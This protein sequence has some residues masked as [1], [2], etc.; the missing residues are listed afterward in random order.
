MKRPITKA[1]IRSEIERQIDSY[2]NGGGKVTNV[3]RG[4]SG[5]EDPNGPLKPDNTAFQ[6]PKVPRTYVSDVVAAIDARRAKK[7]ARLAAKPK[8]KKPRKKIIYD[9]FGEPLRE[10][11]VDE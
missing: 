11:W 2:L 10:V 6:Q 9:D 3:E 5:R 4:L 7:P 8:P 1:D